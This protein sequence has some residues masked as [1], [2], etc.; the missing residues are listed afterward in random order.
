MIY[1]YLISGVYFFCSVWDTKRREREAGRKMWERYHGNTAATAHSWQDGEREKRDGRMERKMD[2]EY[3]EIYYN[4]A[5]LQVI[6]YVNSLK[7][8]YGESYF[9]WTPFVWLP[10]ALSFSVSFLL[11]VTCILKSLVSLK[12]RFSPWIA[13]RAS[14]ASGLWIKWTKGC[15]PLTTQFNLYEWLQSGWHAMGL[16]K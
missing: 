8:F 7:W 5:R 3:I 13:Y 10:N 2:S 16:S 12:H 15:F 9:L 4:I 11:Q 6:Q 14:T 1:W